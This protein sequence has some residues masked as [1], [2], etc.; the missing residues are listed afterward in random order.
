[1]GAG[2]GAKDDA[3]RAVRIATFPAGASILAIGDLLAGMW[4]RT[5][6]G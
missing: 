5:P 2:Q 6:R 1:V 4:T 3:G